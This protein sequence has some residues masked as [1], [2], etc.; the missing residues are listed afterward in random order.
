MLRWLGLAMLPTIV[1]CYPE[2][3]FAT[4]DAAAADDTAIVVSDTAREDVATDAIFPGEDTGTVA[5]DSAMIDSAMIDSAK[6]DTFVLP[7]DTGPPVG[8]GGSTAIFCRDFEGVTGAASGWDDS[9]L[10]GGGAVNLD[11]THVRSPTKAMYTFLPT[12]TGEVAANVH[13]LF[14]AS[15]AS[16]PMALDFWVYFDVIPTGSGPLFAKISRASRGVTLYVGASTLNV[17]AMG[18][19]TTNYKLTTRTISAGTWYHLRIE[20]VLSPV[21][22]G[23]FKLYVDN[24]TTPALEKSAIATTS[25]TGTDVK[26][27]LGL[28]NNEAGN[29]IKTWYDDVAFSFL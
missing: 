9:Y 14:T 25:S 18:P 17:D 21:N 10:L 4:T 29:A 3:S 5:T 26:V 11:S 23:W 20:A 6:P 16:R 19:T 2:F 13:K 22:T 8:C 12:S 1:G 15:S 28:Y 7:V 27:N 24:M